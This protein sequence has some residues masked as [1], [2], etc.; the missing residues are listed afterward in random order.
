MDS[1]PVFRRGLYRRLQQDFGDLNI[2]PEKF[3][4]SHSKKVIGVNEVQLKRV[5]DDRDQAVLQYQVRDRSVFDR[6]KL[7]TTIGVIF[8]D[9]RSKIAQAA[10]STKFFKKRLYPFV[11]RDISSPKETYL[12]NVLQKYHKEKFPE[13]T[14]LA[15]HFGVNDRSLFHG[16]KLSRNASFALYCNAAVDSLLRIGR[17]HNIS[18]ERIGRPKIKADSFRKKLPALSFQR[19]VKDLKAENKRNLQRAMEREKRY[20]SPER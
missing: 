7:W 3:Y 11:V 4:H 6:K 8:V 15:L 1:D 14:A 18:F 10:P 2:L 17:T 9:N 5:F 16:K 13:Q 20:H 12:F 19:V